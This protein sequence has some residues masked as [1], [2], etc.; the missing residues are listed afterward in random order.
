MLKV[1]R[2][3]AIALI[4]SFVFTSFALADAPIVMKIGHSQPAEHLRHKSLL[5]FKEMLETNTKGAIKVEIYHSSQLGSEAEQLEAVKMGIIQATRGG[6]FEAVSEKFV[7]Y[8]MPFL[9]KDIKSVRKVTRGPIGAKIAKSS[10]KNGIYV[11]ATG[12]AGGLRN[13]TNNTRPIKKPE[14]MKGLKLRTPPIESIIKTME[15][16]GASPVSIPYGEVYMALK[17][18]V[19]DGQENPYVN[20]T[21]MKFYEVQKYLTVVN[22]QYHPDPFCVNLKWYKSLAP[23]LQKA[24]NEASVKMME[25]NDELVEEET[26][27]SFAILKDAMKVNTLSSSARNE[28]IKRSQKVYDYFINKGFFTKAELAEIQKAAK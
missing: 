16:L 2:L 27:T 17:T 24:L 20:I 7:L 18:G 28:F 25:Y 8:T 26:E 3:F 21:A 10:E 1:R 19:A 5:K 9:F 23:H 12:D 15:A 14:D 6:A 22:Y 4:L 13:I 11:P